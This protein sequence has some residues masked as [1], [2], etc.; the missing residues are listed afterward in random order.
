MDSGEVDEDEE[1]GCFVAEVLSRLRVS[2]GRRDLRDV[3]LVAEVSV[4]EALSIV[5]LSCS[6]VFCVDFVAVV[7]SG[8]VF[9]VFA[10]DVVV[11]AVSPDTSPSTTTTAAAAA[12][13]SCPRAPVVPKKRVDVVVSRGAARHAVERVENLGFAATAGTL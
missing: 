1:W 5:G 9:I 6:E 11:A 3:S 12:D 7:S 10:A 13:S 2:V 4:V 8:V